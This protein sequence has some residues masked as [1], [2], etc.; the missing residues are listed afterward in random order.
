MCEGVRMRMY[1]CVCEGEGVMV[2]MNVMVHARV[3]G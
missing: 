2:C 1:E 3:R